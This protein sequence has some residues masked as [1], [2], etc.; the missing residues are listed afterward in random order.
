MKPE[1]RKAY[2]DKSKTDWHIHEDGKKVLNWWEDEITIGT[3]TIKTRIQDEINDGVNEY[4]KEEKDK[5]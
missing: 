4:L 2:L 1:N 5:K 3:G